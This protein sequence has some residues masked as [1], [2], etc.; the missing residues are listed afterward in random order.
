LEPS[1]VVV[2]TAG[3]AVDQLGLLGSP[4]EPVDDGHSHYSR[5]EPEHAHG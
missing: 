1:D 3:H 4:H 2:K 5:V